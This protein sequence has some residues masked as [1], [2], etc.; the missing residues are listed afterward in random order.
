MRRLLPFFPLPVL[1]CLALLGGSARADSSGLPEPPRSVPSDAVVP[2]AVPDGT[3]DAVAA[4]VDTYLRLLSPLGGDID[5]YLSFLDQTPTWPRRAVMLGR[6]QR[7]M[8]VAAPGVPGMAQACA[9]LTLTYAPALAACARQPVPAPD[10]PARARHAW[11]E[12]VDQMEDEAAFLAAFAPVLT[13]ADQWHRFMRQELTGHLDAAQ[14]QVARV[15]IGRQALA[16][17]R[18]SL[19]MGWSDTPALLAL[20]PPALSDDPVLVL[21]RIRWLRRSGQADLAA[22]LWAQSGPAA[23][24]RVADP[25]F[26]A[27]IKAAFWAE[28]DALAHDMMLAGRDKEA[29]ALA[30]ASDD[31]APTDRNA[32]R[33]L[34]GWI[35]L[36]HDHDPHAALA[37]FRPLCDA[38]SL[39]TRSRGLYWTG[40]ALSDLGDRD[41]ARTAWGQAA[42]LPGTFY[43]QM[44]ASRLAGDT[45]SPL[46]FP[47]RSGDLVRSR[48]GAI[49]GPVWTPDDKARFDASDLVQAARLLAARHD[50]GHARDFL[51]L[52]DTRTGGTAGHV[53]AA[54]LALQL[55]LPDVAVSIARRA[56][57]EGTALLPLGWP[58]PF[59]PALSSVPGEGLPPGFLMAVI[60]QESGF[61]PGIVSPAGAYGLMQLMP[62]AARDVSRQA[63]LATGPLTGARLTDP[64]LNIRI[65][66]AYLVRLMQKFGGAVPYVL[67]AYNAG[68]HR[69]D[70]WL[71]LLGDP[72]RGTPTAD[73]MLDWIE[74][75]PFAETRSYIQRV[76]ENMAI[77]QA[78]AASAQA[79]AAP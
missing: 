12:G 49:P 48:L 55:G 25:A 30:T 63:R 5:E 37:R 38:S 13:P 39:L 17:A 35:L 46:L 34:S 51:L 42:A 57:R 61:D 66:S 76:E 69:A 20:V 7:L 24:Q 26:A 71:A 16:R 40:R 11:T 73:A 78:L 60:R 21:D 41:G 1:A 53:L 8:A 10:L 29:L 50:L 15:D 68:P 45:A 2:P 3:S 23:E 14:R 62:A 52:Q 43:G 32:A 4:R 67:A 77:Y 75:I 27:A 31:M 28:R 65:G 58:V 72:A 59:S 33:F 9:T 44:A 18:L 22:A 19:R 36:Q 47:E 6:L 64:D 70:E 79:E 54:T 56:G 74:S